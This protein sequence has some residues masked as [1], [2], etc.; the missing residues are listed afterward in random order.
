VTAIRLA[1]IG[2]AYRFPAR[3]VERNIATYRRL[4]PVFVAGFV[5]PIFYLLSIG[6]GVGELIGDVEGP[7]GP[8]P[9]RTFVAPALLATSATIGCIFD[10]TINFFIR[11]KYVGVYRAVLATPLRPRDLAVGEV[12][13]SLLRGGVYAA[14]FLLAM[15]AMGLVESA[16]AV[17][18]VPAALLAGFAFAGVG[19]AASTWM[20]SWLDFD[21]VNLVI[22]PLFLFSGVFFPVTEYPPALEAIVRVS[23]LYQAVVLE[24]ALVLGDVGLGLLVPVVYLAVMGW[25][26]LRVASHRLVGLLQP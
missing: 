6:I 20:R 15:L 10:T 5:E 1:P 3:L 21:L 12:V 22:F 9:Y 25:V 4:W 7:T 8:I 13:W 17:L 24:R 18:A 11:Y 23:P 26:G 2:L 19:L 14:I 16:W